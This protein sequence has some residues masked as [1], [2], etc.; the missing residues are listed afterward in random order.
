VLK[1]INSFPSKVERSLENTLL[2]PDLELLFVLYVL[3]FGF[4]LLWAMESVAFIIWT[5]HLSLH[6]KHS[7]SHC[8]GSS[9]IVI[10][11]ILFLPGLNH[12]VVNLCC[13]VFEL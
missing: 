3:G 11:V 9:G 2:S 4:N 13:V 6:Q 7:S 8:P 10:S 5:S 1:L 12:Q